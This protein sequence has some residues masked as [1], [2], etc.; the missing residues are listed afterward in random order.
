VIEFKIPRTPCATLRV[1]GEG[2]G[3]RIF[4]R[5][6]KALDHSSPLWGMSGFLAAVV[7][8]GTIEIN[9]IIEVSD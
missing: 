9:D 6:V 1:Y 2:I 5:R 3:R 7:K 8:P 4:D